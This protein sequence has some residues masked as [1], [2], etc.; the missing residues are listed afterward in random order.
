MPSRRNFLAGVSVVGAVGVAGCVSSVDTTTGRVFVKSINVE[1]TASDGNATRIDLLTVLFERSENVLHG[2]YDPEYVGSAFDDRT[3]T[4]SDSLHE[5]LKNRFGDVRYLVNVAPV[6]GNEGPVN[7]AATR[8]DFNELTLGGRAT[9]STRSG[10]E[11]FRH[12]R[13]H[14]TEPRSQAISESNVRSFD[15]ESAIDSN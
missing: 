7:V 5:N 4:V 3:V 10:E 6:G 9:V 15:L 2:Q 13:V 1:A 11:E 12:L 8:A 14:D